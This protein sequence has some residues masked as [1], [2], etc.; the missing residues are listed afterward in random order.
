VVPWE[1]ERRI[2]LGTAVDVAYSYRNLGTEPHAAYWC[3][4][5]LFRYEP[6]ME[7]SL[8]V[9]RPAEGRSAK[10]FLPPG[11][12]DRVTLGRVEIRWDAALTPEVGVW[13]CNGD[14]GGYHQ[15]AVEP[16]TASPLLQP[17]ASLAW[18]LRFSAL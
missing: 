14:I 15:V 7:I 9:P 1:L 16:A 3:A 4:H 17:G 12:V 10:V 18:W 2:R 11:S 8:D 5:P 6:D 13:V